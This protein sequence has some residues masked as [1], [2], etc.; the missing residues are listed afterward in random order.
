MLIYE[1]G[2]EWVH[3]ISKNVNTRS[4]SVIVPVYNN[5]GSIEE[6]NSSLL[7]SLD[8]LIGVAC[9]VI[10][11][12]DGSSDDSFTNLVKIKKNN[13][14][15]TKLIQLAGNFGQVNAILAGVD[16][17]KNQLIATISADLQDPPEIVVKMYKSLGGKGR[18][19]IAERESRAD[20]FFMSVASRITYGIMRIQ[21]RQIPKRGFDCW[22]LDSKIA[23]YV[24]NRSSISTMRQV[25]FF[26]SGNEV[27]RI[28]Y[29]R[30]DRIHGKSGYK[31][32][33]KIQ[34]FIE[35]IV[36]GLGKLASYL[37]I[38]GFA[39]ALLSLLLFSFILYSY[40]QN[41]APF[42][43]FTM[44]IGLITMFGSFLLIAVGAVLLLIQRQGEVQAGQNQYVIEKI[45]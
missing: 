24:L 43:G 44:I 2:E 32:S 17:A 23:K 38:L 39:I 3:E 19:A 4:L 41:R 11:V 6:L 30:R 40:T 18:I 10:Y 33:K 42:Q 9:E 15:D 37:V 5:A 28:S 27:Y 36:M 21:D 25:N 45:K 7:D 8:E 12:D 13:R 34:M 16:H 26:N 35:V 31:L 22:M 20:S 29:K 1:D 14:I